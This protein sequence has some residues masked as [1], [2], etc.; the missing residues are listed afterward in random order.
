MA[1]RFWNLCVKALKEK[2][3]Y[4]VKIGTPQLQTSA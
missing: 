4:T 2:G 3:G 1:E